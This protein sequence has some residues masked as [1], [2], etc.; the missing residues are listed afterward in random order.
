MFAEL[1]EVEATTLY[2]ML[3][4]GLYH[5]NRLPLRIWT[6]AHQEVAHELAQLQGQLAVELAYADGKED[7]SY[8]LFDM[9]FGR[10]EASSD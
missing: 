8:A 6:P 4:N 5:S 7:T 1:T 9:A 3:D 10:R 2:L